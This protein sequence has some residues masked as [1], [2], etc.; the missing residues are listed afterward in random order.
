MNAVDPNLF[1]RAH[2]TSEKV[3]RSD[4]LDIDGA[5]SL[6][7]VLHLKCYKISLHQGVAKPSALHVALVEEDIVAI[8]DFYKPKSFCNIEQFYST[9]HEKLLC[10]F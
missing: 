4:S 5:L 9:L 3:R 7:T 2:K 1:N 6:L 10:S 8:F